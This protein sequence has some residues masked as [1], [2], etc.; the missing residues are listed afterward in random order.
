[1]TESSV[2]GNDDR[3]TTHQ[4]MT[5][6]NATDQ[7]ATDQNTA[8]PASAARVGNSRNRAGDKMLIAL[9][10]DGTLVDHDGT[11]RF[12]S[13]RPPRPWWLQATTL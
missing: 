4:N 7:N 8:A 11:C 6:Q 13:A 12:L 1:M 5:D 2:A 3:R 10:V 9:D